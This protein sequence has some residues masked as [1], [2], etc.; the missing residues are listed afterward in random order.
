M[1]YFNYVSG[2]IPKE[3]IHFRGTQKVA[4][5]G[6]RVLLKNKA[7]KHF[8]LT[9]STYKLCFPI[10]PQHPSHHPSI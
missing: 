8:S 10:I 2:V 1:F 6:W 3:K 7:T 5:H 9:M 4:V